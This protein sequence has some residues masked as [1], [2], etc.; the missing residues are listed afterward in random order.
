M[1]IDLWPISYNYL[2]RAKE[3]AA[4]LTHFNVTKIDLPG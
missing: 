4:E 3:L 2:I 1:K